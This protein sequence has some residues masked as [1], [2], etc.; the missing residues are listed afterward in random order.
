MTGLLKTREV[1]SNYKRFNLI[2]EFVVA[3]HNTHY[4]KKIFCFSKSTLHF[5]IETYLVFLLQYE[6]IPEFYNFNK[7]KIKYKIASL[8]KHFLVDYYL[9]PDLAYVYLVDLFLRSNYGKY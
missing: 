5:G 6:L 1:R 7:N 9:Y 3:F 8:D 2:V 4:I